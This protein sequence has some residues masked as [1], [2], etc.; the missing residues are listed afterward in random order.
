MFLLLIAFLP[1]FVIAVVS[2]VNERKA[3]LA[4]ARYDSLLVARSLAA[5]QEQIASA[6][7]AM[8]GTLVLLDEVR[9][10]DV[11]AC[12]RI[13]REINDRFPWYNAILAATPDGTVFASSVPF[14]PGSVNV[15]D[16][17]Y[18]IEVL[19]KRDFA[20][21]E[22]I[23]GRIRNVLSFHYAH[24]VFDSNGRLTVVVF[25]AFDLRR[26]AK[27]L[28]KVNVPGGTTVSVVD[29]KGGRLFREPGTNMVEMGGS[30][31][32]ETLSRISGNDVE[33]IYDDP[34][35]DGKG[36]I[37]AFRQL[38]L[39]G[40]DRPY[41]YF[42]VG[43]STEAIRQ[44]AD[45]HLLFSFAVLGGAALIAVTLTCLFGHLLLVRP[46]NRLVDASYRFGEGD[47]NTRTGLP[48]TTDELGRLAGAFDNMAELLEQ[49]S[50][51]RR[52]AE[53]A[54]GEA[55]TGLERRVQDRT[56]ELA[57]SNEAL[58]AMAVRAEVAN[59]AKS[60][61]LA[62]MS[63]EIR[64][65][66][67]GVIG[68]AGLLIDTD[69]TPEQREY[70]EMVRS[71]GE[72][73]LTV[74]NDILDF[75]KMETG[76]LSLEAVEFDLRAV[77][78]EVG[79]MLAV[80]ADEKGIELVCFVDP[81]TPFHLV[82]DPF[83]L[84]QIVTNLGGNALKFTHEGEV[85]IRVGL[86]AEED[87]VVTIRVD[88]RDTGIGIPRERIGDL[89]NA[90]T[91]VDTSTTREYGGTGLGLTI[92]RMLVEMMGGRIEV[93][94]EEGKGSVFRFTAVFE[95]RLSGVPEAFDPLPGDRR[96]LLVDDN[97]TNRF[98]PAM[99]LDRWGCRHDEASDG[100][101][102]LEMLRLARAGGDPYAVAVLDMHMP[103]MDGEELARTIKADPAIAETR[104]VLT[105]SPGRRGDWAWLK[106][107]GFS[108]LL[109]KPLRKEHLHRC[110]ALLLDERQ[111]RLDPV[112]TVVT[113]R[114]LAVETKPVR[115]LLAEDNVVN[116]KVA[117]KILANLGYR[118]DIVSNGREAVER[119]KT[120]RYDMVLMDCM[121]PEMD[122]Y[123]AAQC[124]REPAT[125]VVDPNVP[126]VALTAH[127]MT[128]DREKCLHAG[129]NDYLSKP[130]RT[131]E[132]EI[133][134]E[135][136]TGR[137]NIHADFKG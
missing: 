6:T 45:R 39:F 118:A 97:A 32:P 103:G 38:R 48:H 75:S 41:L 30:V 125:G 99:L 123:E 136:W 115:I 17:K 72:S 28:N 112:S 47:L 66:M 59:E 132:L 24:P 94:S 64:T 12:N 40:N 76:K 95:K 58:Q 114:G 93:E 92:T 128:G 129:M 84:R 130:F 127:A 83:R 122:G 108:A 71:G 62:N 25:A 23:V 42:L 15:S 57:A 19:E 126:I 10:M 106:R 14:T 74:I 27:F 81:D 46:V 88:V 86:E 67:N 11:D 124:I 80:R 135:K 44:K 34:G 36:Q 18:F 117:V 69:L 96:V 8:L 22:Y 70:A 131:E 104:L 43:V 82:G 91:Q 53:E 5:Q 105:M 102:A 29:R 68:M 110:L 111:C 109:M 21:G 98:L 107:S 7:R 133:I 121:M 90:F 49:R 2:N 31:S 116:Q 52:S 54:L 4:K 9:T 20:V 33:G 60:R 77:I 55:Y 101:R 65:P 51:Q 87:A 134:L 50:R 61:F 79:D 78:H 119:L 137:R 16:R 73:L 1:G 3:E 13:F 113:D 120:E 56:A 37:F 35:P 63:H 100:V 85:V 89:F 26:L